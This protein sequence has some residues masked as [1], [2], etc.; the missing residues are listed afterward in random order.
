MATVYTQKRKFQPRGKFTAGQSRS[1]IAKPTSG[2]YSN[3]KSAWQAMS[4]PQQHAGG[5]PVSLRTM[6]C[7][8]ILARHCIQTARYNA[9]HIAL[10]PLARQDLQSRNA[11][12]H[13]SD[14]CKQYMS[15]CK[16][17]E[18]STIN[19]CISRATALGHLSPLTAL[20]FRAPCS[21]FF[22]SLADRIPDLT[23]SLM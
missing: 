6:L 1:P 3:P 11:C 21:N 23:G 8:S 17:H 16:I 15:S 19:T 5:A 2:K 10:A 20:V 4:E 13:S 14:G 18:C 22:G 12:S 9:W 7:S